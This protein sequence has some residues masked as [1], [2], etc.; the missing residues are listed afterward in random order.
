MLVILGRETTAC[1]CGGEYNFEWPLSLCSSKKCSSSYAADM[2]SEISE[3]GWIRQ[4][5]MR[6]IWVAAQHHQ[7]HRQIAMHNSEADHKIEQRC[8]INS[9]NFSLIKCLSVHST[10]LFLYATLIPVS[11]FFNF[12]P[13]HLPRDGKATRNQR[14]Y[15]IIHNNE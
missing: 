2:Y 11:I 1:V 10:I 9:M 5:A 14:S 13:A 15:T 8:I 12:T 7:R 6:M 3:R 4:N